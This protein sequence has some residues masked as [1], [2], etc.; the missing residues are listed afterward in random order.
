[1]SVYN[2]DIILIDN[3]KSKIQSLLADTLKVNRDL[4]KY[5]TQSEH[6][7]SD[8]PRSS[9]NS[10]VLASKRAKTEAAM[11]SLGFT[12]KKAELRKD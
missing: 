3:A 6:S 12:I 7:Y 10:S 4:H 5:E 1:L 11:V 8:T 2:L 9:Q